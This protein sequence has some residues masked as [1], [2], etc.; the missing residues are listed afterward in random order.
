MCGPG[1]VRKISSFGPGLVRAMSEALVPATAHLPRP[2]SGA[3]AYVLWPESGPVTARAPGLV[4]ACVRR[5]G[6]GQSV[7]PVVWREAPAQAPGE[8]LLPWG[9]GGTAAAHPRTERTPPGP[10]A[11]GQGARPLPQEM[12][13]AWGAFTCA[14][15]VRGVERRGIPAATAFWGY[16]CLAGCPSP[17][18]VLRGAVPGLCQDVYGRSSMCAR[19]RDWL[20]ATA[21]VYVVCVGGPLFPGLLL[22]DSVLREDTRRR[23]CVVEIRY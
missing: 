10:G 18:L 3:K 20:R 7:P 9:E 15:V 23:G 5:P 11:G 8:S 19:G 17:V 21:G 6:S 13:G 1:L 22:P 16:E 2:G 14:A 12:G 4:E